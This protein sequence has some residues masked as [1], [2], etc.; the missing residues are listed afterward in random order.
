LGSWKFDPTDNE[1][2]QLPETSVILDL[3]FRFCY[4]QRHP[5]LDNLDFDILAK[6]VEA[7]E[8]Y[9]VFSAINLCKI[10]MRYVPCCSR[11]SFL[12]DGVS[13]RDKLPLNAFDILIYGATHAYPD[14]YQKA[15]SV[16]VLQKPTSE[17]LPRLPSNLLVPWVKCLP[18]HR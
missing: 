17:I 15:A 6:L 8:K 4:P 12:I 14:V 10:A 3:L 11:V 16:V 7:V 13:L 9:K 2:V 1:V 5:N 18:V